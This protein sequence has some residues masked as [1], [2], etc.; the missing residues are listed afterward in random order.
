MGTSSTHQRRAVMLAAAS[1]HEAALQRHQR[2][3]VEALDP[4]AEKKAIQLHRDQECA[5]SEEREPNF[6]LLDRQGGKGMYKQGTGG[7]KMF[8]GG[9]L[10]SSM[11]GK[12]VDLPCE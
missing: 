3:G 2:Q 10:A 6:P 4:S 12:E 9:V 8:G 7:G 1:T 11:D 5:R